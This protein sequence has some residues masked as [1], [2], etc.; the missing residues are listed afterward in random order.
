[1]RATVLRSL[2]AAAVVV[3]T[4][5]KDLR[6]VKEVVWLEGGEAAAKLRIHKT[7]N[8]PPSGRTIDVKV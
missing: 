3:T 5:S 1:M 2:C 8:P 4:G 7:K 6:A